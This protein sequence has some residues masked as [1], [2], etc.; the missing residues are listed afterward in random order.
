M[1]L[2]YPTR[3]CWHYGQG[4][5]GGGVA[6]VEARSEEEE[7]RHGKANQLRAASQGRIDHGR[8]GQ[9]DVTWGGLGVDSRNDEGMDDAEQMIAMA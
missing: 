2:Y 9:N 3:W 5:R 1:V 4:G 6:A 7:A 8:Q